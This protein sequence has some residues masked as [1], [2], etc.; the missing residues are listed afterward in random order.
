MSTAAT[1]KS[2]APDR[3]AGVY[4][5]LRLI[6]ALLLMTVGGSAMFGTIIV[7][8]PVGLEFGVSR[9]TASIPYMLYML[10]FGFG[11]VVFGRVA[12]RFGVMVPALVASFALPAGLF[13]AAHAA[14]L[15]QFCAAM[16]LLAGF[17][18]AWK[19][20]VLLRALG[21]HQCRFGGLEP[22]RPG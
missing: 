13:A 4:P 9:G 2:L 6:A 7:L 12:D 21:F 14:T 20:P 17:L 3:R 15:W 8:K 11:G 5:I 22:A 1:P 16:G 19:R 10:G 18:G